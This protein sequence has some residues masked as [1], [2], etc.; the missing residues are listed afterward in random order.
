MDPNFFKM[1]A[2]ATEGKGRDRALTLGIHLLAVVKAEVLDSQDNGQYARVK[3]ALLSSTD[4]SLKKGDLFGEVFFTVVGKHRKMNQG[5]LRQISRAIA[6]LDTNATPEQIEAASVH[7]FNTVTNP[8]C[9]VVIR[10]TGSQAISKETGKPYIATQYEAVDQTPTE[11]KEVREWVDSLVGVDT[12]TQPQQP[13]AYGYQAPQPYAA[14]A[15]PQQYAPGYAP[16]QAAPQYA[17]PAPPPQYAQSQYAPPAPGYMPA[18][19]G[20]APP[21]AAPQYPPQ[22]PQ[23]QGAEAPPA[24]G[25]LAGVTLT[26]NR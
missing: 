14:Q 17:P 18:A 6:K 23:P 1:Y 10:C 9:G 21:Q 11:I 8:A 25:F 2:N 5:R 22:V 7:I 19:P 13:A 12:K 24:P 3:L 26:P 20:Y 4:T 16:P 15:A